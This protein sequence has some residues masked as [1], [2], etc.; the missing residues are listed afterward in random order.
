MASAEYDKIVQ[1]L[2]RVV[3]DVSE[4][5]GDVRVLTERGNNLASAISE[6]KDTLH[7]PPDSLVSRLA[8]AE[9][10]IARQEGSLN[11]KDVVGSQWFKT[12]LIILGTA[13]GVQGLDGLLP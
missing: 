6:V 9:A 5:K 7:E 13:L 1:L 10:N 12:M 4:L 2:T 8:A 3:E 11:L